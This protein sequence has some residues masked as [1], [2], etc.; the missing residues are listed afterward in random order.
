MP[1]GAQLVRYILQFVFYR[2]II[3]GNQT[4]TP[5]AWSGQSNLEHRTPIELCVSGANV[6]LIGRRKSSCCR[7]RKDAK[8]DERR[9]C[10]Y[11]LGDFGKRLIEKQ[12]NALAVRRTFQAVKRFAFLKLCQVKKCT[13]TSVTEV[14][15]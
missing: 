8:E 14:Q 6:T 13:R 1:I 7:S 12:F 11:R 10:V 5:P 3:A 4:H 15:K 9:V 2:N